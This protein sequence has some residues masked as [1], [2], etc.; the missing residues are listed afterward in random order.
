MA[1]HRQTD[2]SAA[3]QI[4]AIIGFAAISTVL[5]PVKPKI[6]NYLLNSDFEETADNVMTV[7]KQSKGGKVTELKELDKFKT[8]LKLFK[9]HQERSGHP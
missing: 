3:A 1:I 4:D 6:L 5:V 9:S 2:N 8:E 7:Y